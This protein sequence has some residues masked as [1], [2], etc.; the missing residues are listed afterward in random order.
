[1]EIFRKNKRFYFK[2]LLGQARFSS[3]RPIC[4]LNHAPHTRVDGWIYFFA[5]A[6]KSHPISH[7]SGQEK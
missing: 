4:F 7:T 1:M 6:P 5:A 2:H 3:G